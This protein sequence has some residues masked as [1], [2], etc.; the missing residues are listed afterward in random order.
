[1]VARRA[2]GAYL[3]VGPAWV[4]D[5][6]MA[7][8]LFKLLKARASDA[9]IDVVAP[10][11]TLPLLERMPE[12]RA[13]IPLDL[14]HGQ[15]DLRTRWRIGRGL[16]GRG[17]DQAIVLP[18][19]LKSAVL[20]FAA[21]IPRRTGFIGELRY[22]L[23]ND[24]RRLDKKTLPRTVDRFLALGLEAGDDLPTPP[25]P[26]L[27]ASAEAGRRALARFGLADGRP[28][29][30]LV[31]CPGA[32]YGPAKRWPAASF[33]E[34]ANRK[35]DEGWGVCLLGSQK[36]AEITREVQARVGGRALDLAGKTA[37]SEAIDILACARAVV[38][39]DSGLMHVAAALDRPLVAVFGSSDPRHTPPLSANAHIAYLGVSCSPCFARDCPLG[40]TRC[41]MDLRPQAVLR[42][43]PN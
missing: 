22:G 9:A 2:A 17:Y 6:V 37:L 39:N 14:G 5:M 31:L 4:G 12:V 7:Q 40:H 35:L 36:D 8:S 38:T 11:W 10:R 30:M 41:L 24:A 26:A 21:G 23:L 34:V 25:P 3:V 29:P 20:P 1:M 43:L 27:R 16:R 19:S 13:A 15:L 42:V 32:E 18:N 33:A 28:T